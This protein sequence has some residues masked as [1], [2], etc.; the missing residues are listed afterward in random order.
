PN[1]GSLV[2]LV[3][4]V[5]RL[6]QGAATVEE[7]FSVSFLFA[8]LAVPVRSIGWTLTELPRSVAGWDRVRQVLGATGDMAYGGQALPSRAGTPVTLAFEDVR[9]AYDDGEADAVTGVSFEVP[10]GTTLALVGPTGSG[11]STIAALA[12]RLIDP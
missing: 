5:L 3:V 9:F 6:R 12:A 11:K 1:L 10:A 7:I 8:M 4:G 2:V